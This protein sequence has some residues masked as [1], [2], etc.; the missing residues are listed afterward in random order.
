MPPSNPPPYGE[1]PQA[2]YGQ[3]AQNPYPPPPGA[4]P[5]PPPGAYPPPPPGGAPP[6]PPGGHPPPPRGVSPPPPPPMPYQTQAPPYSTP[7]Q[8]NW[9]AVVSLTF[10]V[11]GGVLISVICWLLAPDK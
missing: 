5:P 6:P 11:I 9:W 3:P 10:G 1:Q 4:Y 7:Q 2:P 8:T